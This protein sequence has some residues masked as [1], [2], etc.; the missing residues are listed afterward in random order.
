MWNRLNVAG[1]RQRWASQERDP[2]RLA[3][4]NSD[5]HDPGGQ[6]GAG[7]LSSRL[8][9]AFLS[10]EVVIGCP[11]RACPGLLVTGRREF[12][13]VD[14]ASSRVLLRCTR[15][16]G[17]HEFSF[18]IETYTTDEVVRLKSSQDRGEQPLC[19]RCQTPLAPGRSS[20]NGEKPAPPDRPAAYRCTW[21]GV[22]WTPPAEGGRPTGHRAGVLVGVGAQQGAGRHE[23]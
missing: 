13:A 11:Q 6:N 23:G 17:E 9:Q 1:L 2:G 16:P 8:K 5:R 4:S 10:R 22:S 14:G 21:C 3:P 19:S 7:D 12:G 20:G 18:A 15:N